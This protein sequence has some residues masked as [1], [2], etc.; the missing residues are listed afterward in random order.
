MKQSPCD[1]K[2]GLGN[3]K[4]LNPLLDTNAVGLGTLQER[5]SAEAHQWASDLLGE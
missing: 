2:T 5:A 1:E 4:W 3:H